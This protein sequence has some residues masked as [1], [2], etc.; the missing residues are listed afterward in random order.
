V[1]AR[2]RVTR[3]WAGEAGPL[4]E[5]LSGALLPAEWLFRGAAALRDRAFREGLLSAERVPVPVLSVGNLAV[6]GAGKTPV[7]AW[8]AGRL[9]QLG[10]RPGIALRGYGG[11]EVE[12][13]R[14]LNP[15]IPVAAAAR[16]AD[17]ARELVA[18]GCGVVVLDDGFQHRWL[19]RDLD[20]VLVAAEGWRGT[21]RLLPRG[22]WREPPSALARASAIVITRKT[23]PAEDAFRVGADLTGWAP[24]VPLLHLHL[25][26]AGLT[27]LDG[28]TR[29]PLDW[30]AGRSLL[31]VAGLA[32][33]GPFFAALREAGAEV[34]TLA[35]PDHHPF[36]ASDAAAIAAR[37][38]DRSIV[39][40]RKD[41]VKLRGLLPPGTLALEQEVRVE[42]GGEWLD[43]AL[44]ALLTRAAP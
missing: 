3:W 7:A 31:A 14:E 33:P 43:A 42:L 28:G 20:L 26:P 23:A 9:R 16:R 40:T 27:T 36:N 22:P 10:A 21:P 11:D 5:A 37:A 18:A 12:L 6:G 44:R 1:S 39:I 38:Q 13:H 24:G 2:E 4:G 17:A 34:E 32:T 15:G 25:A 8:L 41:A 29:H 30:L 19:A 35:F